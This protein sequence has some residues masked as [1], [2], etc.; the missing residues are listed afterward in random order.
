MA[1]NLSEKKY[2]RLALPVGKIKIP[3]FLYIIL[4]GLIILILVVG[5]LYFYLENNSKKTILKSKIIKNET[6]TNKVDGVIGVSR[7]EFSEN[8]SKNLMLWLEEQRDDRGVYSESEFCKNDVCSGKSSSNRSGF[9]VMDGKVRYENKIDQ[10]V[11]DDLKKYSDKNV[12]R[13][14]QS[15]YLLCNFLYDLY[16][17]PEVGE[18]VKTLTEK[19]C[20]DVQYE[21]DDVKDFDLVYFDENIVDTNNLLNQNLQKLEKILIK[22]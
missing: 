17:Y 20:F 10:S 15:N 14:I 2:L 16:K 13:V 22:K 1:D 3:K 19:I 9:S 18:E 4:I 8:I 21:F 12:V 7:S 6:V 5:G 11:V